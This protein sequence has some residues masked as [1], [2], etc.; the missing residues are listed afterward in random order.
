[1]K[2]PTLEQKLENRQYRLMQPFEVAKDNEN[3]SSYLV[4]GYAM[5]F[6]PY[7][8][9]ETEDGI[10]NEQFN[11]EAFNGTDL[12]DVIF[13]YDHQG[14]VFARGSNGTLKITFDDIGMKIQADLSKSR[15]AK[16]MYDEIQAGLV[17]KMSWGFRIGDYYF[18][19]KTRTIV[20]NSIKKVYDVSAVGIPANNDT[21]I[22]A[23]K[24]VNGVIDE[25]EAERLEVQKRKKKLALKIEIEKEL[26]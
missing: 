6:A 17:T 20:H 14:K 7:P 23:R 18:D 8:L 16:E 22:N 9:Y 3:E 24:F 5:K 13:L 2:K 4:E 25:F 21:V 26:K 12:S 10:V 15:A 1:M 11:R 19:D